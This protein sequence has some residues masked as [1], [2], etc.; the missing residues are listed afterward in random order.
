M[1]REEERLFPLVRHAE[2][3]HWEL[4]GARGLAD[5]LVDLRAEHLENS[6]TL[7]RLRGLTGDY[8][9]PDGAGERHASLLKGLSELEADLHL[10]VHKENNVL[11]PRIEE[12]LR[13]S[14]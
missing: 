11:F 7:G 10:H 2:R 3:V 12:R 8:Q 14:V 13:T 4:V 5:L 1:A 6:S 9:A